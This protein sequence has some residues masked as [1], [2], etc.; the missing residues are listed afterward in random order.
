MK[1]NKTSIVKV[2][3]V[4]AVVLVAI[5]MPDHKILPFVLLASVPVLTPSSVTVMLDGKRIRFP[6]QKPDLVEEV[7]MIPLRFVI[8][9]LAGEISWSKRKRCAE[10]KWKG[11]NISIKGTSSK[12]LIN[13]SAKE[14]KHQVQIKQKRVMVPLEFFSE[15]MELKKVEW[16]ELTRTVVITEADEPRSTYKYKDYTMAK[17]STLYSINFPV[18]D[19]GGVEVEIFVNLDEFLPSQ[20]EELVTMLDSKFGPEITHQIVNYAKQKKDAEPG[21]ENKRFLSAKGYRV[22][23]ESSPGEPRVWISVLK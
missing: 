20:Y 6:D 16:F 3:L 12:V 9:A 5:L 13:N 10:I 22:F 7:V 23:V 17:E 21:L 14:M 4:M 1:I 18:E 8:E 2:S 19:E 11:N 15:I